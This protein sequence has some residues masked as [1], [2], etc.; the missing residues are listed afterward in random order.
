M[1][2]NQYENYTRFIRGIRDDVESFKEHAP[3]R[4]R[5][6]QQET[7]TRPLQTGMEAQGLR[8]GRSRQSADS[9][10]RKRCVHG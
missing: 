5:A 7:R 1:E 4:E 9:I 8:P 3:F 2:E 10:V 6:I